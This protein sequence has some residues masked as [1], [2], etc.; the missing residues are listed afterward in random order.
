MR[1][2]PDYHVLR[3]TLS[4]DSVL[5]FEISD[6]ADAINRS[7]NRRKKKLQRARL[8]VQFQVAEKLSDRHR[9]STI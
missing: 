7:T 3:R 9:P 5:L 1:D 2:K 6:D 8:D 4:T